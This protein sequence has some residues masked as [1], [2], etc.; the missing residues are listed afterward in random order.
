MQIDR[1]HSLKS[2]VVGFG[3][4][5]AARETSD[6]VDESVDSSEPVEN[7]VNQRLSRRAVGDQGAVR[8]EIG[9]IE[10]GR[11]DCRRRADD[12]RSGV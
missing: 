6:R 3:D 12:V 1:Q 5:F 11:I 9:M 2:F 4:R 8:R 7:R 10:F